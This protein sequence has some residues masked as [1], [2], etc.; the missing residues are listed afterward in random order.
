M[1]ILTLLRQIEKGNVVRAQKRSLHVATT[2]A[3]GLFRPY[4]LC[5]AS[6]K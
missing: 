1:E 4:R 5:R 6:M 2:S 3:T